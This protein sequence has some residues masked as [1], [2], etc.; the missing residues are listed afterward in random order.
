VNRASIRNQAARGAL[1]ARTSGAARP[2]APLLGSARHRGAN[3]AV[4]GGSASAAVRNAAALNGTAMKRK[5]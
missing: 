1:P 3:P 2:A 4:V 5:P